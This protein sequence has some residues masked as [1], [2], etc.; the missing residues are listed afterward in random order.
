MPGMWQGKNRK[1][2]IGDIGH[3]TSRI[4]RRDSVRLGHVSAAPKRRL[5]LVRCRTVDADEEKVTV[6]IRRREGDEEKVTVTIN[7]SRDA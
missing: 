5:D 6:T 4:I 3:P 7:E 1:G 2:D